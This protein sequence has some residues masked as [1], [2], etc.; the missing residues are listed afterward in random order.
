ML[1]QCGMEWLNAFVGQ[2]KRFEESLEEGEE[3]GA[4]SGGEMKS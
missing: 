4:E 3:E 2:L 1:M